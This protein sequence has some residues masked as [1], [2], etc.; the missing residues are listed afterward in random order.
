MKPS[1]TVLLVEDNGDDV[2]LA[3]RSIRK[4]EVYDRIDVARD[5]Q[6][7]LDYFVPAGRP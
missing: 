4:M 3:L 6:E 7:A 5:G 2:E 1:K